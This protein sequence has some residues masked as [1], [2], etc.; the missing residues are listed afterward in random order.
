MTAPRTEAH[1]LGL[2]VGEHVLGPIPTADTPLAYRRA[3]CLCG[4]LAHAVIAEVG[5][6]QCRRCGRL[7]GGS[8]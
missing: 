1:Y 6:L 8:R 3:E 2:R 5:P 4:P 7:I